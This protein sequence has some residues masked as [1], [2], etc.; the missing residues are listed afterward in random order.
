[1]ALIT[2]TAGTTIVSDDIDSNF[3]L[4]VLTD[5]S[6]TI[7]VTHTWSASQ[8]MTGIVFSTSLAS[9]TAL[10][11]PSAYS[12]TQCT[13]FASTVSGAVLMGYGT[14]GD[15]TLK[16]RAG[17]SVLY[18]GP[19]TTT[20]TMAGALVVTGAVSGVTDLTVT[21]GASDTRIT[22]GNA[23]DA[24]S[25][26]VRYLVT[27]TKY[28]WLVGAQFVTDNGFEIIPSTATGGTTFTTPVFKITQAGVCTVTSSITTGAPNGGTAAA[29]KLGTVS[30]TSPTSPNRT[31][32]LDVAGT[33]YYLH[34][35]TTNN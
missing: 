3:A 2:F 33:I 35:K 34:A 30:V 16:N 18:V 12:A 4:C 13:V 31:I 1:M 14:T 17:T 32:E 25:A 28:N 10:A 5:T 23:T 22:I 20:V 27:S 26:G 15:V 9:A 11:T 8:T 21:N 6:K 7:T 24:S 29:W 19:N